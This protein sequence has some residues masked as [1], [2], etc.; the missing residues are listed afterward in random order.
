M[1]RNR[2][3]ILR[4]IFS[5]KCTIKIEVTFDFFVTVFTITRIVSN[6]ETITEGKVHIYK[7]HKIVELLNILLTDL[8]LIV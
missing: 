8:S 1:K 5:V 3:V 2:L 7:I 4:N 6:N